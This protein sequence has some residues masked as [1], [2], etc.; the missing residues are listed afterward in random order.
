MS[1]TFPTCEN[2]CIQK[3]THTHAAPHNSIHIPN[4]NPLKIN[5][6]KLEP[7]DDVDD[8]DDDGNGVM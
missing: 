1:P 2:T 3:H 5:D 4:V 6:I 8:D 7:D